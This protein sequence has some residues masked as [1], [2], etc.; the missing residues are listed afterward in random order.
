M[1]CLL[2]KAPE[3]VQLLKQVIVI[4]TQTVCV[5]NGHLLKPIKD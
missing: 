1:V 2:E 5:E 3:F 4:K